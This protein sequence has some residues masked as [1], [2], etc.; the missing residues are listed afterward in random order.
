ML[1]LI[2]IRSGNIREQSSNIRFHHNKIDADSDFKI[3]QTN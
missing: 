1:L 2:N 3:Q